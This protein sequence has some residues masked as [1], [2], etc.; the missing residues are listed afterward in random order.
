M[1]EKRDGS[2]LKDASLVHAPISSPQDFYQILEALANNKKFLSLGSCKDPAEMY[3]A[4]Q[5]KFLQRLKA[6]S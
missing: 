5:V 6:S 2:G 1:R 4:K 3:V